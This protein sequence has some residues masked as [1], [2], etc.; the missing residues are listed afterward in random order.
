MEICCKINKNP[1][2]N[3][4][5]PIS[6][7]VLWIS[8]V[9]VVSLKFVLWLFK[10]SGRIWMQLPFGH[11]FCVW[12]WYFMWY[13]K[14]EEECFIWYLNTEKWLKKQGAAEFFFFY[15]LQGVWILDETPFQMFDIAS[16]TINNSW[17]KSKQ[18]F[19]KFY[20]N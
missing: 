8:K 13:I 20:D 7:C 16:Q 11:F 19:A 2:H 17:R 1:M 12:A 14:H 10:N 15:Q 18:K 9:H 6:L 3:D 5:N 4:Q